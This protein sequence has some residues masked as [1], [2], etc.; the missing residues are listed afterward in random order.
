VTNEITEEIILNG[1]DIVKVGI[2]PG[3]A[4]TTR[5]MTGVGYPQ[6]SAVIECAD[7][8]H[9][10]NS[11][12]GSGLIIADGGQQYPSCV[13]KAFCGGAD[14]NMF[15]S[16]FSGYEES[17]GD[18]IE[19]DGKKYKEYFGSS[20]NHAMEKLYGKKDTHRASEGRYTLIP[21]KGSIH[22]FVQDLFGAL[23]STGTYIGART[24]KEFM[25]R[26]TFVRVGRQL[27]TYLEGYDTGK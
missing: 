19:K 22:P 3:S 16:M 14:F 15:G 27:T 17:G 9:G 25:K 23:R 21:F 1:A 6:L 12:Q 2:G 7:A 13:A 18:T 5:R 8:A 26:A 24:L 11:D 4:C 10:L 20:S